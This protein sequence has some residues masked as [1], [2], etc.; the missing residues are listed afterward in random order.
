[1]GSVST[2]RRRETA[3]FLAVSVVLAAQLW[4]FLPSDPAFGSQA[5]LER[6]GATP[7]AV[8]ASAERVKFRIWTPP[9]LDAAGPV[10]IVL[11]VLPAISNEP[12][13]ASR[14]DGAVRQC[15]SRAPPQLLPV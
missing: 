11:A 8:S 1:M 14:T 15:G 13:Q 2:I 6:G 9:V 3:A 7:A 5:C 12:P 4:A 10:R